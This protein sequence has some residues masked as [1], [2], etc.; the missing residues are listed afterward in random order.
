MFCCSFS[1]VPFFISGVVTRWRSP[2]CSQS[3]TVRISC[4]EPPEKKKNLCECDIKLN[5][6]NHIA[7]IYNNIKKDSLRH[8]LKNIYTIYLSNF[9]NKRKQENRETYSR[10]VSLSR[11]GL[12][13]SLGPAKPPHTSLCLSGHGFLPL[14]RTLQLELSF[15]SA[16]RQRQTKGREQMWIRQTKIHSCICK[17]IYKIHIFK[18]D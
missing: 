8:S 2:T 11:W 12:V 5:V 18:Q 9:I 16:S 7:F 1:L 4:P 17:Y 14:S 6:L 15:L 10:S 3:T 13:S